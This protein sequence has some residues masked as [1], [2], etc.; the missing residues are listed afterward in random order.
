MRISDWSSVVCSSDL[1]RFT[2]LKLENAY[3]VKRLGTAR[4]ADAGVADLNTALDG[5]AGLAGRAGTPEE[6]DLA[7]AMAR[8]DVDRAVQDGFITETVGQRSYAGFTQQADEVAAR[9]MMAEDPAVAVKALGDADVFPNLDEAQRLALLASAKA[10][11]ERETARREVA[12]GR[13]VSDAAYVL[14][15]GRTPNNLASVQA[16]ASGT[17]Y[18]ADLNAAIA[19]RQDRKSTRLNSSH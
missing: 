9:Q 6:Y 3:R 5:Y 18:E 2:Q 17:R 1:E 13:M 15:R 10:D 12:A 14:A 16:A 8:E 11:I 19:S 7:L 4:A